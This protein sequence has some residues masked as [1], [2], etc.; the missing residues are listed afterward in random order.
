MRILY[1][2]IFLFLILPS[3]S[4]ANEASNWLEKEIDII[5]DAYKNESMSNETRFLMIE[6]TINYNFA[7]T[8]I[9]KFVAGDSWKTAD[10]NTKKEYIKLFKRHL[11]LNIASMMQ[12]YSDQ[13][14][15]LINS[16]YDSKNQ[17]TL[18]DMEI[19]NDTGSLIVTWRVKKSKERYYVI[20][21]L[22]AD[23]SIV[24]TKRSEFN[25]MLKNVNYSLKE[26]NII[27]EK[28]NGTS[29]QKLIN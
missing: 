9:A 26:L 19:Y 11:A 28:Q 22:V 16:Q 17:I 18:I 24:V 10:K 14:Y 2:L 8:G 23:I 12:G 1:F 4:I 15:S 3:Q 27:L 21:L 5:L 13:K 6:D 29:Y 7:G 20:D 25:S